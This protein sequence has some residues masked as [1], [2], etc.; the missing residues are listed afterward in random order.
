MQKGPTGNSGY[1]VKSDTNHKSQGIQLKE[2]RKLNDAMEYYK[3]ALNHATTDQER[4][5][6]WELIIQVH[7]DRML[8]ACQ[9]LAEC[10]KKE[11]N[12]LDWNIGTHNVPS[13]YK[14]PN[15]DEALT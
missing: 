8:C 14:R 1:S 5:E 15:I 12:Q 4:S 10:L 13:N 6:I 3:Q 2:N 11:L 9:H 7:T